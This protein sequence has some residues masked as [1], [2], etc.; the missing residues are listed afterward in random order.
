MMTKACRNRA[1]VIY[2]W[3]M[4]Q[5]VDN[6]RYAMYNIFL[7]VP[8]GLVRSL[9]VKP[10]VLNDEDD[11]DDDAIEATLD[12][13]APDVADAGL[14]AAAVA[15]AAGQGRST[16]ATAVS[17][18]RKSLP[19]PL[20]GLQP[21]G[22]PRTGL[23]D[24]GQGSMRLRAG[25]AQVDG[26]GRGKEPG[27]WSWS[28]G[29]QAWGSSGWRSM[30][31]TTS[32]FLMGPSGASKVHPSTRRSLQRSYNA[33]L[34]LVW[35]Y[36][37]WGVLVVALN[38]V[39]YDSLTS[40]STPISLLNVVDI[41]MIRF[42][43]CHLS[44]VQYVFQAPSSS[45]AQRQV[46]WQS[47]S[48]EVMLLKEEWEVMVNGNKAL[49]P[50]QLAESPHFNLAV[51]GVATPGSEGAAILYGQGPVCMAILADTCLPPEHPYY[52]MTTNGLATLVQH[53][54]DAMDALLATPAANIT[55]SDPNFAFMASC[56]YTVNEAD[57]EG[58][59]VALNAAF[60]AM[61]KGMYE[62]TTMLHVVQFVLSVLLA[63]AFY[64]FM[65]RPFLRETSSESRRI[66]ELLAQLP[67]ELEVEGLVVKAIASVGPATALGGPMLSSLPGGPDLGGRPATSQMGEGLR[68]EPGAKP[69]ALRG[70]ASLA[71]SSSHPLPPP[72]TSPLPPPP[73]P[74]QPQPHPLP[75][76]GSP[77]LLPH[78]LPAPPT[79][80][81]LSVLM[82]FALALAFLASSQAVMQPARAT[83][84]SVDIVLTHPLPNKDCGVFACKL[85]HAHTQALAVVPAT[86]Q[87]SQGTTTAHC[88][89]PASMAEL[90]GDVTAQLLCDEQLM[91]QP[92]DVQPQHSHPANVTSHMLQ[93]AQTQ[94]KLLQACSPPQVQMT[95]SAE[96]CV[97]VASVPICVNPPNWDA[98]ASRLDFSVSWDLTTPA[99][100][101]LTTCTDISGQNTGTTLRARLPTYTLPTSIPP[102][103]YFTQVLPEPAPPGQIVSTQLSNRFFI[104][105]LN[106][107][108]AS[109]TTA[110]SI[111]LP[112]N[113]EAVTITIEFPRIPNVANN[114]GSAGVSVSITPPAPPPSPPTPLPPS[115]PQPPLPLPPPS[116]PP[117]PSP[118][119]PTPPPS[120][121][122]PAPPPSPNPPNPPLPPA[123]P[124][125][126]PA[127]PPQPPS[128]PPPS[129]PS[130]AFSSPPP[131]GSG[132]LLSTPASAGHSKPSMLAVSL[133]IVTVLATLIILISQCVSSCLWLQTY[134]GVRVRCDIAVTGRPLALACGAAGSSGSGSIGSRGVPIKQML[135]EAC[136]QL[137][138]RVVLVHEFRTSRVS[139]AHDN[140]VQG[141]TESFR[142]RHPVRSMT[143]R[144]RIRGLM[145]S[146][147]KGIRLYDRD[148]SA[149][150]NIRRIAAGLGPR[151]RELS[152]WPGRPA[153]PD[154]GSVG[155]EWVLVRV[156]EHRT[157]RVSSA[158]NGKQP[159][160]RK[161]H[162]QQPQSYGPVL[163]R[164][165][166]ATSA[167][168]QEAAEPTQ[169]TQPTKGTG[170]AQGK[171]VKAK[172]S[173]QPGRWL[174]RDCNAALN[175]QRI[176]E[177]KWRP[178]NAKRLA[179]IGMAG[180]TSTQNLHQYFEQSRYCM[181]HATSGLPDACPPTVYLHPGRVLFSVDNDLSTQH[182]SELEGRTLLL[183]LTGAVGRRR[184]LARMQATGAQ[185]VVYSSES[186]SQHWASSYVDPGNWV[187]GS[188][189]SL[190]AALAAIQTWASNASSSALHH[191]SS[192]DLTCQ[193][194]VQR[195]DGVV[196]YDEYGLSIAS[197]LAAALDLPF[198]PP[199]QVAVLRNKTLFRQACMEAGLPHAR[200]MR[201]PGPAWDAQCDAQLEQL[202]LQGLRRV[203]P[204]QLKAC[205]MLHCRYPVVVK[206]AATA[207]SY[208][209]TC[210]HNRAQLV[211]AVNQF[212]ARLPAYLA[213]M[214]HGADS[215]SSTSGMIVEELLAGSEV[216]VDCI[217]QDGQLLFA[218]VSDNHPPGG[219]AFVETGGRCPF[220]LPPPAQAQLLLLTRDVV[221][222]FPGLSGVMHF[223][224][225]YSDKGPV[226]IELNARIGG[227]ETPVQASVMAAWGVDL[228]H[229]ALRIAAG[230]PPVLPHKLLT[231]P[232]PMQTLQQLKDSS[233][234]GKAASSLCD[235]QGP[236]V[237]GYGAGVYPEGPS[238]SRHLK[239]QDVSV[240][241]LP[242]RLA[243]A[244]SWVQNHACAL[245]H[246]PCP[247]HPTPE[248]RH[249][250]PTHTSPPSSTLAALQTHL[251]GEEALEGMAVLQVCS[252]M[253]AGVV[254]GSEGSRLD[255]DH[256][257]G[258][259]EAD[260]TSQDS[261]RYCPCTCH[262]SSGT[263]VQQQASRTAL[264]AISP[265][266]QQTQELGEA[267]AGVQTGQQAAL[268]ELTHCCPHQ[269]GM[270]SGA[271]GPTTSQPCLLQR[272]PRSFC[273]S[274]NILPDWQGEGH[275]E[276]L[277]VEPW[278]TKDPQLVDME[279]YYKPGS[280]ILLPPAGNSAL[281]WMVSS[282]PHGPDAA[283][284]AM[285]RLQQG[286]VVRLTAACE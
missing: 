117:T 214:G 249:L 98:A 81:S 105:G 63:G 143:T 40:M 6:Q 21:L 240:G 247:C 57:L 161:P 254:E 36:V 75:P 159:S 204:V 85:S 65:L 15:Q 29:R 178:L 77:P 92:A 265:V 20:T 112:V 66:A 251:L 64:I 114:R 179:R 17:A 236:A 264:S 153:M 151:P 37:L 33:A 9:V 155:Q 224:A 2:M 187:Q 101:I 88:E 191:R 263:H 84:R 147:S 195:L 14:S 28:K 278:V 266:G 133:P 170:K 203:V 150:L 207:G 27:A 256:S 276:A 91:G 125:P 43:R 142:R 12:P 104:G 1:S 35:P 51:A 285:Q 229:A 56:T 248:Q 32:S 61:V 173:P 69:G 87:T 135:W 82:L 260:C 68:G 109:F 270:G 216:D 96:D 243:M 123:P 230:L 83:Q 129:P 110:T 244:S 258:G 218:C 253:T 192:M 213:R 126:S 102:G 4:A 59:M 34:W 115:P 78:P 175:M 184:L 50:T 106:G 286:L 274:I 138:G 239:Q 269:R 262:K 55:P 136:K 279:L 122:S 120:P 194:C 13:A 139:S 152:N 39:R 148:V 169:L 257:W 198:T 44:C 241:C 252:G 108:M 186:H 225:M 237:A 181:E 19:D 180:V 234:H 190:P 223:E 209:V 167:P 74:S 206:P 54:F 200:F 164:Q 281:G 271:G 99:A 48:T 246:C 18:V 60:L 245:T 221:A 242:Y 250:T 284:A 79:L 141:Q 273:H 10:V 107:V 3:R 222:M 53:Y 156:S 149:A 100:F 47:L 215:E 227:A 275:L 52:Q 158:V 23:G 231:Q 134:K 226:P 177:S 31:K 45:P 212:W 174:D 219:E 140:V 165:P 116:P 283:M 163:P 217:V 7:S 201:V 255:L 72:P 93:T 38:A 94:R 124:A 22:S 11:D 168:R 208:C 30:F 280:R 157:T 103:T 211:E 261:S 233:G 267:A 49:T 70:A 238:S 146:T 67:P 154:P 97:P 113:A 73:T 145:C 71:A 220:T 127:P 41:A 58:G 132:S 196:C 130:P 80:V 24:V 119:P 76:L 259:S 188:A 277:H 8:L 172:P 197:Q 193:P 128:P 89:L 166:S 62:N 162:S 205:I 199:G 210:A 228:A 121:P 5:Q 176:G 26:R 25:V 86:L 42:H 272:W 235:S 185:I 183:F 171:A 16:A 111:T 160:A 137:P 202:Q 118:P 182:D 282:S 232:Q 90:V 189:C 95:V 268:V 131:P 46:L 144:S